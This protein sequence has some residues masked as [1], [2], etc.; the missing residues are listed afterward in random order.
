MIFTSPERQIWYLLSHI[1]MLTIE[2]LNRFYDGILTP[3]QVSVLV[4]RMAD[5]QLI[6]NRIQW[7]EYHVL[8][9][10]R[11]S[12][13][14][15]AYVK[16]LLTALWVP[17]Q[18]GVNGIRFIDIGND[19]TML[20]ILG[21]NDVTYDITVVQ[22]AAEAR[23]ASRSWRA[24]GLGDYSDIVHIALCNSYEEGNGLS[25]ILLE[26][27]FDSFCTVDPQSKNVEYYD[28]GS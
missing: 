4:G 26:S 24:S 15:H 28:L 27:G 6:T 9:R 1:P 23:W 22:N 5:D 19:N 13:F 20:V 25:K 7:G 12:T 14:T 10:V 3:G 18:L 2:H 8:M 16:N 11:F 17:A 21:E